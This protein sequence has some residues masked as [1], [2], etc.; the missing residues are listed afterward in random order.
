MLVFKLSKDG[1]WE[2]SLLVYQNEA[3][4]QSCLQLQDDLQVNVNI[5]L[6]MMYLSKHQRMY[7]FE[8][9]ASIEQAIKQ[10]DL[11]LM[12]HRAKRRNVKRLDAT[13]YNEA[14]VEEL[15]LEKAQQDELVEH[16][17]T[18]FFHHMAF[19]EQLADQLT[20]LCLQKLN[21]LRATAAY[22]LDPR[23]VS[24]ESLTACAT[25]SANA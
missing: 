21:N 25:L 16:A 6:S 9:I 23:T 2:Y 18:L 17:N 20:G 10:S 14:L 19:P 12:R 3:V 5:V 1:L 15:T 24:A 4:K 7:Q 13:L 22:K 8:D 11:V